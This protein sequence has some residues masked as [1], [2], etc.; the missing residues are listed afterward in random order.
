M[1]DEAT[2]VKTI[3][4]ALEGTYQSLRVAAGNIAGL[5]NVGRATCDE[6]RAYNLWALAT[7]NAQRGMLATLREAGN[8]NVPTL[9]TYP[10][11]FGWRGASGAS[12]VNIDCAGQTS[13]LNGPKRAMRRALRG[14]T[15]SSSYLSSDQIDIVDTSSWAADADQGP[16]WA[17]MQASQAGLGALPIIVWI[18]IAAG[19]VGVTY[20]ALNAL[21]DYLKEN[22]IQE[23]T[24]ERTRVQARAFETYTAARLSCYANCTSGGKSAA[25]CVDTCARL[26]EKPNIIIDSA[27]GFQAWGLFQWVGAIVVIGTGAIVAHKVYKK[28][29]AGESL[30]PAWA[31]LP[32]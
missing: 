26:V 3:A 1:T 21:S 11:L 23:E 13:S 29:Q 12:A 32:S 18:V 25:E 7:Y 19:T 28:R 24:T 14:P 27:R 30:L 10:Q 5:L 2:R 4:A 9:P 15:A 8:P 22:A 6:V 16:S 17:A 31:H 20:V